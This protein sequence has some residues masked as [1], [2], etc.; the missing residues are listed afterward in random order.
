[1]IDFIHGE[2]TSHPTTNTGM[3][4]MATLEISH[5]SDNRYSSV[6]WVTALNSLLIFLTLA[7]GLNL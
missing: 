1:M 5:L 2:T 7:G 3:L 6:E 4:K